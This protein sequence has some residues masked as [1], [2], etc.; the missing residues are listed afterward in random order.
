MLTSPIDAENLDPDEELNCPDEPDE[1]DEVVGVV[2]LPLLSCC[3]LYRAL[4]MSAAFSAK[5]SV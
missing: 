2:L 4:I 1:P 3:G 5:I